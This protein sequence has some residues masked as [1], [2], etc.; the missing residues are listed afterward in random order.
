MMHPCD[1]DDDDLGDFQALEQDLAATAAAV[2]SQAAPARP[3]DDGPMLTPAM[4]AGLRLLQRDHAPDGWP[5]V[6]MLEI[7]ALLGEVDKLRHD[8]SSAEVVE[9]AGQVVQDRLGALVDELRQ[10]QATMSHCIDDM[11]QVLRTVAR[12][13]AADGGGDSHAML[14]ALIIRGERLAHEA[15]AA[16]GLTPKPRGRPRPT[17][18]G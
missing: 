7:T 2:A 17:Q 11:A 3:A 13:D 18:R 16:A 9:F 15:R 8:L 12:A 6:R 14:M 10:Q 4:E 5:A 1:Y